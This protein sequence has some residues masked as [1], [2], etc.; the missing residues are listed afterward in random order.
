MKYAKT[1][2]HSFSFCEWRFYTYLLNKFHVI[3]ISLNKTFFMIIYT[4]N[5]LIP[6]LFKVFYLCE[7]QSVDM[8]HHSNNRGFDCELVTEENVDR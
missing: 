6:V 7:T 5:I 1:S 4:S 3:Y 8:K 2:I